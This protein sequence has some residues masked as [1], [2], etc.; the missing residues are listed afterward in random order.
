M[1]LTKVNELQSHERINKNKLDVMP[2]TCFSRF[3][4]ERAECHVR[5][6]RTCENERQGR[7]E[8]KRTDNA[9]TIAQSR[10]RIGIL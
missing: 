6:N 10:A 3:H 4:T 9:Q 1:N 5:S 2:K 8:A 7:H